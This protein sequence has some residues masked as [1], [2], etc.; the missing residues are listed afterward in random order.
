[1]KELWD[2]YLTFAR[3]GVCTFGG[4]LTMLPLLE[5][6][7]VEKKKWATND[8]LMD[9]YAIGQCTPGIIAV[10]TATFVG[11][12]HKGVAGGIIATLG[13]VTPSLVIIMLI[14]SFLKNFVDNV[15]VQNAFAAVR[16]TVSAL[17]FNT[18]IRM[19]KS[20]VK[21]KLGIT[22]AIISLLLCFLTDISPVLVVLTGGMLG[23]IIFAVKRGGNER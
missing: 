7:I 5:A 2:L 23:G 12:K 15:T 13:L 21:S 22:L 9:Y 20:N 3:I 10:N 11:Y 4:G 17:I 18:V 8:E 16:V 1:M 6:E 19:W 14:A